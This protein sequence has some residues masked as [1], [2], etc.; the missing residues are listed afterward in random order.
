MVHV[1]KIVQKLLLQISINKQKRRALYTY[2]VDFWNPQKNARGGKIRLDSLAGYAWMVVITRLRRYWLK[3]ENIFIIAAKM[4]ICN[5]DHGVKCNN[6][7]T[8]YKW[9]DNLNLEGNKLV[10]PDVT[11]KIRGILP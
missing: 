11:R 5:S 2:G 7:M 6:A 8:T 4:N 3:H 1:Q 10:T 9:T